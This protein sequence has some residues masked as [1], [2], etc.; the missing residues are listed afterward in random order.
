MGILAKYLD[1]LPPP[2]RE[3]VLHATRWT[4]TSYVDERGA[5][6]LLGHAE[7]WSWD[8]VH[9]PVCG[10]PDVF[11]LRATAGDQTLTDEPRIESRFNRLVQRHGL[12]AAV[13]IVAARLRR[14]Q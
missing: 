11:R 7:D 9:A 13:A 3:R 5:R 8:G 1:L 14:Y 12:D 10:A 2:A 4:T 6:N